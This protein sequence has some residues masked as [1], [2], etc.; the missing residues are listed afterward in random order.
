MVDL[1]FIVKSVK[2]S[3]SLPLERERFEVFYPYARYVP[4]LDQSLSLESDL[5]D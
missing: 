3:I 5:K 4:T 1:R 2:Q